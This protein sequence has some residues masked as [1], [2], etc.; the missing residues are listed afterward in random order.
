[1]EEIFSTN[2]PDYKA[3]MRRLRPIKVNFDDHA[4][5]Q[6]DYEDTLKT[7]QDLEEWKG[8][9][10]VPSPDKP[11]VLLL[12]ILIA[13]GAV[14]AY[15][16]WNQLDSSLTGPLTIEKTSFLI[17]P[18]LI[19]LPVFLIFG[20]IYASS[21]RGKP[22]LT[23]LNST[24]VIGDTLKGRLHFDQII[25]GCAKINI[26]LL[27]QKEFERQEYYDDGRRGTEASYKVEINELI[28]QQELILEENDLQNGG[29][30]SIEFEYDI[31][32]DCPASNN[33]KK[34]RWSLFVEIPGRL[35]NSK[36]SFDVPVFKTSQS[37]PE[38]TFQHQ[39]QEYNQ[40]K[41]RNS[42]DSN[43]S[44]YDCELFSYQQIDDGTHR[45]IFK[46]FFQTETA[47]AVALYFVFLIIAILGIYSVIATDLGAVPKFI[48]GA[49]VFV[50]GII[51]IA[52][53][54]SNCTKK[55]ITI[56]KSKQMGT[57][58]ESNFLYSSNPLEFEINRYIKLFL[59]EK[60]SSNGMP[61]ERPYPDFRIKLKTDSGTWS[62]ADTHNRLPFRQEDIDTLIDIFESLLGSNI[63]SR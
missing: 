30:S 28:W 54:P 42:T 1:M 25:A 6:L 43:P 38:N 37:S 32:Y 39:L 17:L 10:I 18:G 7:A 57:Y 34:V 56:D 24:G 62:F 23:V 9:T 2:N 27:C 49:G 58:M 31:P 35:I 51:P 40:T 53:L 46:S 55:I 3:K 33:E 4:K 11:L 59:R 22:K 52:L 16:L 36:F 45:I 14:A 47:A 29:A 8:A 50:F 48:L 60:G 44:P 15:L 19:L 13:F 21:R 41:S 61:T 63:G 20:L 26:A 12:I 5:E